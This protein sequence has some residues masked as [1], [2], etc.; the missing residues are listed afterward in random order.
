MR[1][2]KVWMEDYEVQEH[3]SATTVS[4]IREGEGTYD[5]TQVSGHANGTDPASAGKGGKGKGGKPKPKPPA[6]KPKKEKTEDQLARA[7]V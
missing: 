5:G 4:H 6:D 2:Y 1:L 3:V 7:V